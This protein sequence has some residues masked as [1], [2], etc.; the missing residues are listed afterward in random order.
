MNNPV[1]GK[2]ILI[3][4][5]SDQAEKMI[6]RLNIME[7]KPVHIPLITFQAIQSPDIETKLGQL[8]TYHWLFFTS[9]NGVRFFFD[10][11]H[12][13]QVDPRIL[14][15][16]KFA[17]IGEKTEQML[18]LYG[19]QASFSPSRYQAK[20]MA[21]QFALFY[22]NDKRVLLLLGDKSSFEIQNVLQQQ[23]I[24][25]D[26]LIVYETVEDTANQSRLQKL[27]RT[28]K[29]DVYTFTSPSTVKSF[30]K[31]TNDLLEDITHIRAN[32]LCVCIGSTTETAAKASGF[33]HVLVPNQFTTEKM[34]QLIFQ[35]FS[36]ESEV[37]KYE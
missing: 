31:Q 2:R 13:Y 22:G 23:R 5:S 12:K 21:E 25:T 18:Q 30:D 28:D 29:I 16:L 10:H 26:A 35:Y 6:E 37:C 17:V 24:E 32:R 34:I 9:A 7:A 36:Q 8:D 1:K 14:A 20:A 19:Y 27:I 4:R 33:Q 15:S 11:I 3:T